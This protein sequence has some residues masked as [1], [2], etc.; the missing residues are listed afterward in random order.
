MDPV[1]RA[2]CHASADLSRRPRVLATHG[3]RPSAFADAADFLGLA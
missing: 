2:G 3:L 1:A